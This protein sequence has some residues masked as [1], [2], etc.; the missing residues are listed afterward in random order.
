MDVGQYNREEWNKRVAAGDE[1]TVPVDADTIARARRGD[2]EVVLTPTRPVPREWF[3]DI[4]GKDVLGLASGGGQQCPIFAAAGARVSL[5]DA[6]DAQLARDE[7]VAR[8]ETLEIRTVQGYMHDLSAFDDASFDIVFN[9]CSTTFAPEVLP[10]WRECARVLRPGGVLMTGFANPVAFIFDQLAL[11]RGELVARHA[12]PYSDLELSDHEREALFA[13]N[14]DDRTISFSH[15]L[16]TQ[17]GGQLQAGFVLTDMFE[18]GWAAL[19]ALSRLFK[20]FIATRAVK[21]A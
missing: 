20:P 10:V 7:E 1:W 21:P 16:E 17:I 5:L 9:P 14:P 11:E 13:N 3:G 6:S 19:D 18:D 4:D 12:L 2:W 15:T 8:R